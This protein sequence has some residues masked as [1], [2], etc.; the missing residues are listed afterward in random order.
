MKITVKQSELTEMVQK[1]VRRVLNE[2][3]QKITED[4]YSSPYPEDIEYDSRNDFG[5]IYNDEPFT[6]QGSYTVSNSGGYEIMLS[7]DGEMARVREAF[8][9]ENPET[10]DWLPIE[11][12]PDE[13]DGDLEPVI[14]PNGY[15][16]PLN[17]VMRMNRFNESKKPIKIKLSELKTVI[18]EVIKEEYELKE[19][20]EELIPVAAGTV[21]VFLASAGIVEVMNALEQGKLGPKGQKLAKFLEDISRMATKQEPRSP[22]NMQN[23]TESIK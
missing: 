4:D 8:G 12:V 13:D 23:Q 17:Q 18:K 10:S 19:G 14:D 6:P 11:Y 15:N 22:R 16:I 9:G 21:G 5:D 1:T 3:K 7:D 20:F 2:T